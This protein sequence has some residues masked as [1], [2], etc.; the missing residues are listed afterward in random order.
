MKKIPFIIVCLLTLIGC[1]ERHVYDTF[2]GTI[3]TDTMQATGWDLDGSP[4][5]VVQTSQ[6]EDS[7][8]VDNQMLYW[9]YTAT[10]YYNPQKDV[11]YESRP[12]NG[13][14]GNIIVKFNP[15]SVNPYE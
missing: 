13:S 12:V 3:D 11:Y 10:Y 15:Y 1:R 8:R 4:C 14:I 5:Y 2:Y 9:T 6:E 7:D